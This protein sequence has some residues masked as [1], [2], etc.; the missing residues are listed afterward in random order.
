M[1]L[2]TTEDRPPAMFAWRKHR[3]STKLVWENVPVPEPAAND[4]L[5]RMVA[6]GGKTKYH[7]S[8]STASLTTAK[9]VCR[10]DIS[11]LG[12]DKQANWFNEKYTLVWHPPQRRDN[13]LY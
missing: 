13:T 2:A 6:S 11:L 5:V 1:G 7:S 10:S 9:I 3:G 4:V 12:S 8:S